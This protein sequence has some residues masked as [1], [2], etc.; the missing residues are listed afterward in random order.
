MTASDSTVRLAFGSGSGIGA[1][2]SGKLASVVFRRRH[3]WRLAT[4]PRQLATSC[5]TGCNARAERM[6]A[7]M[8]TPNDASWEITR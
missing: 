1:V 5:S 7:A 4:K 3:P 2:L 6:E 8:I